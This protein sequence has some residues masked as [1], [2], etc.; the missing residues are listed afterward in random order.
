MSHRVRQ[1]EAIANG[2]VIDHLPPSTTL[3]IASV[4]ADHSD[5][6]FIGNNLKS[7]DTSKPGKGVIK[8]A[9]KELSTNVLS[10]IA[11]LAPEA[12]I[13]IIRD[14]KVTAKGPISVPRSFTGIALCGNHNCITNHDE[15]TTRFH[16][17]NPK[18][19]TVCCAYCERNFPADELTIL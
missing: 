11:L 10:R 13:N 9:N 15:C 2:T 8:I 4:L 6:V 1:V 17:I 5:Q 18:P 12:T 19:L 16:V 3:K 7:S 14:Y